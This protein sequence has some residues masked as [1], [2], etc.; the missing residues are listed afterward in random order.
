MKKIANR[1]CLALIILSLLLSSCGETQLDPKETTASDSSAET[2]ADPNADDLP[3]ELDFNNETITML[4]RGD[5]SLP[6]FYV[7]EATGDIVDDALF[8]RNQSVSER[9]NVNFEFIEEPGAYDKRI[10]FAHK[11][12]QSVL[13]NDQAYDVVA[14][15]SM[16]IA[17]LAAG[18]MLYNL[19][20]T[21]YL[22]FSKPWWS[23]NLIE[24]S[25]ID[26]KLYFASG[27]ISTNLIYMMYGTFF[28]K[29]MLKDFNLEEPYQMV[30]DGTW[31]IDKMFEMSTDVYADLNSNDKKDIYD[32]FGVVSYEVFLDAYFWGSGL[33]TIDLKNDGTA[34]ISSLFSSEKAQDL[35]EKLCGFYHVSN[36]GYINQNGNDH[37]YDYF[38]QG[39][40]MFDINEIASA[41]K[42]MRDS[43][44]N[45][46]VV[47]IPKYDE[48]QGEY[49]T[50]ASF[51]YTLYGIPMNSENPDMISAVLEALA[52]EG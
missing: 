31:T 36:D 4:V 43:N 47:P 11:L 1:S 20:E 6:E 38:A 35:L 14:G 40:V 3:A 10:E 9:L 18:G 26:G 44:V 29:D 17:N 46:G 49:Y 19:N 32:R 21:E 42:Y 25:S 41:A 52:S 22:D 12:T 7:E 37:L 5:M 8:K 34:E 50:I 48:N 15:Y 39:N 33:K 51:P 27:D 24:Q 16:A 13:A 28:N 30:L 23:K 2:T 45:Y